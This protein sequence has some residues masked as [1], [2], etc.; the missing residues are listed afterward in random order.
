MLDLVEGQ[1]EDGGNVSGDII[2][3]A[4]L[5]GAD[6]VGLP[7]LALVQNGVKGLSHILYIQVAAQQVSHRSGHGV[8]LEHA[9]CETRKPAQ[10]SGAQSYHSMHIRSSHEHAGKVRQKKDR[11]RAFN[12]LVHVD[13]MCSTDAA[14]IQG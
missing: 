7:H 3:S 14:C 10:A 4:L 1:L 13:E 2:D 11:K 9:G 5:L 6:V 12:G 8:I